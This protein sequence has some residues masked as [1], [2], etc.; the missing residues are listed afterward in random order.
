MLFL[1]PS[2][3]AAP[4]S[5][6]A[7]MLAVAGSRFGGVSTCFACEVHPDGSWVLD[8][9]QCVDWF[10]RRTALN[11]A[12]LVAGTAF[13]FVQLLDQL[14]AGSRRFE[15]PAGSTAMETGG[16][17]GRSRELPKAGLH[18]LISERLGVAPGRIVCEYGM[19]E[20]GSQAYDRVAGATDESRCFHFPHWV[21]TRI[22]SPE[23]GD[24]VAGGESGLLQIFDPVNA[25]SVMA[26]QTEDLVR[27]VGGGFELIGRAPAAEPRGCSLMP[28]AFESSP[29]S[30]TAA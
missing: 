8:A 26:V 15:L 9:N 24:E 30:S 13:S 5:S 4:H 28:A 6:L 11:E 19:S 3:E 29:S 2:P 22:V 20:L 10:E 1:V 14:A 7:E 12:C 21:R 23:S 18:A 16:Y 17:K 27:K 25:F